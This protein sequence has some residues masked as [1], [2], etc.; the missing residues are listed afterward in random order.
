MD[1]RKRGPLAG[2]VVAAAVILPENHGIKGLDDSKKLTPKKRQDLEL[3]IKEKAHFNIALCDEVE[4]EMHN[5]LQASLRA[6]ARAVEGLSVTPDH[7]LVDGNKLP[8]WHHSAEAV[9]GGD[10]LHACISAASILAKEYRDGLMREAAKRYPQYGWERNKGY[11]TKA[12]M[13]ALEKYGPTPLHRRG[14]APIAQL[15]MA[16]EDKG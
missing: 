15:V 3:E 10:A 13:E 8:S 4:I 6:M 7:I 12:H 14:F 9:V 5:I 2:P 1:Q 11:G 16:F